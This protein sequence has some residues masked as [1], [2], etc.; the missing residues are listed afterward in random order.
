MGGWSDLGAPGKM[1]ISG[2]RNVILKQAIR[3]SVDSVVWVPSYAGFN[4]CSHEEETERKAAG[5]GVDDVFDRSPK[6][7]PPD[8]EQRG[9]VVPVMIDA[10]PAILSCCPGPKHMWPACLRADLSLDP[11]ECNVF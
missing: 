4:R 10:H 7:A 1:A 11:C 8:D 2:E 5:S 6:E 3:E 9:A